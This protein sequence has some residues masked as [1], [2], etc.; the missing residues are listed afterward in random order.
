VRIKPP[1]KAQLR[2]ATMAG[3]IVMCTLVILS[4][5]FPFPEGQWDFLSIGTSQKAMANPD[6]LSGWAKRRELTISDTV[7]PEAAFVEN[8]ISQPF[9]GQNYPVAWHYDGVNDHTYFAY[10]GYTSGAT[11]YDLYV[12]YYDHDTETWATPVKVDDASGIDVHY[13]PALMVDNNGYI[14]IVSGAGSN[15]ALRHYKSNSSENISAWTEQTAIETA[16][17]DILW[18]YPKFVRNGDTVWLIYGRST[19]SGGTVSRYWL[20]RKST[21]NCAS[22]GSSQEIISNGDTGGVKYGAYLSYPMPTAAYSKI[23]VAWCYQ[24]DAANNPRKNIYH[25]YLNTTDSKMYSMA[26][27]DLGAAISLSEANTYCKVV[28]SGSDNVTFPWLQ[29]DASEY[30]WLLYLK[31]TGSGSYPD[32][33]CT[34][35]HTRW[36]GSSWTSSES[37]TTTDYMF[38]TADFVIT[39]TADVDAYV[40]TDGE[41]GFGGDIEKWNWNGTA[42]SKVKTILTEGESGYALCHPT[43]CY[44]NHADFELVFCQVKLADYST[45]LKIYA[46]TGTGFLDQAEVLAH[47][48]VLLKL[49]SSVGLGSTDV[50][51]IFDEVGANSHKIAVTESD[52]TTQLYVEIEKWDSGSEVAWLHASKSGWEAIAGGQLYFYYD[53]SKPDNDTYVG[54]TNDEIAENVWNS[55]FLAVYHMADGVD[56]EH[57]Y[58]STSN[59]ND[60]TKGAAANPNVNTSGQMGNAQEFDAAEEHIAAPAF[61]LATVMTAE[62]WIKPNAACIARAYPTIFHKVDATPL[63]DWW[64]RMDS[65]KP[66]VII[67]ESDAGT[68]ITDPSGED[69]LSADTFY[70]LAMMADGSNVYCY[71][72]DGTYGTTPTYDGTIRNN[73][74]T[75]DIGKQTTAGRYWSGLLD[76]IRISDIGRG[77]G[78]LLASYKNGCDE[79]LTWGSEEQPAP[80]ITNTPGSNDFG[81][82]E[83]NTTGSTVINYFQIENT[84]GCA[85]DVVVYGTDATGGDDTWILSDT[86]TPGENIYGLYAGLDDEDDIFDVI[87]RKTETYNTLVSNLAENA[88]QDWGLKIYMPTSL[89]GY[90]CNEMS[91]TITLVAS[92][93]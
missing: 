77:A 81:I 12:T 86:A 59:D 40:T 34:Y 57:I 55:N 33:T 5:V 83:V 68:G 56:N 88:T 62:A 75:T 31:G 78:W 67:Y 51:S 21:D 23:H 43:V 19:S 17:A 27:D 25:A 44:N 30:P 54:D 15:V 73:G 35:Y 70:Y 26:D 58:D 90:D 52:G 45:Q 69:A 9:I 65:G 36:N 7:V 46:Y 1:N 47:F 11:D 3:L 32:A 92:A 74:I 53:N 29:L 24:T 80:E 64:L 63:T 42:W 4:A 2:I 82:L 72:N 13:C 39:S 87:V 93:A 37:I 18:T 60:A 16:Q 28:D 49:G 66:R 22:W 8:G 10:G 76:E 38:Q 41:A 50:T 48:P 91:A 89:S 79:L 71:V 84:G 14:H 20:V 85:V 6:W 61:S